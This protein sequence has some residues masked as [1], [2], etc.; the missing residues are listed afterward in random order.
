MADGLRPV[1]KAKFQVF[2]Y[3]DE[4]YNRK[5]LHSTPGYLSSEAFEAKKVAYLSV[6]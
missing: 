3:I 6:R 5:R 4:H 1:T 2:D